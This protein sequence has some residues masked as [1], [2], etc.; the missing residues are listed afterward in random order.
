MRLQY[1]F[2]FFLS[3]LSV[4]CLQSNQQG[5][6]IR[7]EV[8]EDD[9]TQITSQN[10]QIPAPR[11]DPKAVE[12]FAADYENQNRVI[13]QKPE[14]VVDML[15]DLTNKTVADIG[16]G[17]GH[18]ALR[19]AKKARRVIAVDIDRKFTDYIDSVKVYELT[20]PYQERL[21][22]RLATEADPALEEE[23]LD[24]AV[25]VNTYM[26][27]ENRTEWLKKI[28]DGLKPG[29]RII[30]I[31]FKRKRTPV[32]PPS[33]YRVPLYM[34]EE[35]LEAAGLVNIQTND[36]ALDYQYIVSAERK[37]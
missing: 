8:S 33:R 5:T 35:E 17:T 34:A 37:R 15:G 25:I 23:E 1:Y 18:F 11:E 30:I 16:A 12:G 7:H 32:G 26:Y 6:D 22:T 13:W 4:S 27:V 9:T 14:M 2:L 10:G 21:I 3:V 28:A 24:V 29:G 20:K 36:A 19:L 31:D